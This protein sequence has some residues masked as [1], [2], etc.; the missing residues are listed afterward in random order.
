VLRWLLRARERAG[1]GL[2]EARDAGRIGRRFA[3]L[4]WPLV[5]PA[6]GL[7]V[8]RVLHLGAIGVALGAVLGMYVR[9]LFFAYHVVWRS[10][11]VN[12]PDVVAT[13]L[14][15]LLGPA[16]LLLG[17]P[18]PGREDVVRLL[19]E[20][21]DPA[22]PWIH[23]YAVS[24]L[25]VVVVP[26]A[27]LALV[28]SR[29]LARARDDV[30]VDLDAAYYRDLLDKARAVSPEKLEA[31]V[32]GAVRDECARFA[33][34]LAEFVCVELYDGCIAPRLRTFREE[35]GKLRTLEAA[36]GA[37]CE[38]FG[39]AL[40]REVP[41]AQRDLERGLL[42]RVRRLLGA[43]AAIDARPAGDLL[44][45][46]GGASARAAMDA[47]ERMSADVA[48][49]VATVVSAAVAT[50]AGTVSGGFGEALGVALLVGLVESGP[51]GWVVGAI[52]GL[53]AA[54]GVFW[55]GRERL[56]EGVKD[57]PLPAAVL[58]VVLWRGRYERLIAD[59]RTRCLA[60][61]RDGLAPH[62][63]PL[64]AAIADHVWH[65]LRRVVG[66]LQRPRVA[67]PE[68]R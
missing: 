47:G 17:R 35:G 66:E 51:V 55:L 52:G 37:E 65:G 14:R 42:T 26:R 33:G 45:D 41:D 31:A 7:S 24:A 18:L 8:R 68:P 32:R 13:A 34:R 15:V 1:E 25:L 50:V 59:G 57:V 61:V 64:A 29:R 11:F 46:V 49:V 39:P 56:R 36:L 16:A 38:R 63:D 20:T 58:K 54:G 3:L 30:A 10:T 22:A 12:D 27:L 40:A 43:D 9:G 21:G 5:R 44:G 62:M 4:W 19:G 60:A 28:A 2:D 67:A 23:L 6:F 48:A 53:V